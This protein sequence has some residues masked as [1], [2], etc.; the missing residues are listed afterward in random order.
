MAQVF[1]SILEVTQ[2]ILLILLAVGIIEAYLYI[3]FKK[4]D[5]KWFLPSMVIIVP[6]FA[7]YLFYLTG[8]KSSGEL[9]PF[10]ISAFI[11]ELGMV[12]FFKIFVRG[13]HSIP[14]ML[15]TP[16]M[17]GLA[18]LIVYPMFFEAYLAF[19]DLKLTSLKTWAETG[20]IDFVGL[21]HFFR[22]FTRSP[23]TGV[24]FWELVLRTIWWTFINVFFHVLGGFVFAMLMNNKVKFRPIYRTLI[25]VP[26]AT[27][28]VVCI[29]ALRGEFHAQYGF[30]N[31]MLE[32]LVGAFPFL[33]SWGVGPVEW[34]AEHALLTCILVNVWLGIPFMM[35]II[36]G[37]LQS[38]SK[39]FYDA[40]SIDGANFFQK[41][42]Y[43]TIP[44][45]KPVLG[46]AITLGTIWTFNNINV[47]FLMTGQAGGTEDADILVTALYKS[48][49]TYYR[50]S[51][52]AAFAMVI[53]AILFI[54]SIF[55]L[56]FTKS[57]ESI[58]D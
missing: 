32:R 52:S 29:L 38:I 14:F 22:V 39:S 57:T 5:K 55:W 26:W 56:K 1:C 35:I 54:F 27:P 21:R 24:T 20:S 45:V 30:I 25:V 47:I 18:I 36:L 58:Y 41:L 53:F 49:F 4:Y 43:V 16:A 10:A 31:L 15:L 34:L 2:F 44:L 12:F 13:R 6:I 46:P 17:I 50:Y 33:A 19:H 3:H 51:Y 48:A 37:G 7:S 28:I 9:I 8:K 11:I 40:A 42:R 23:M